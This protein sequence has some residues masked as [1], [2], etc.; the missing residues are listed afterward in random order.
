MRQ[1]SQWGW[2]ADTQRLAS[3]DDAAA[4]ASMEFLAEL[5]DRWL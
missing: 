3:I 4:A 5:V 2:I 1:R